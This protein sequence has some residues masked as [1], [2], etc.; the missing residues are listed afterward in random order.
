MSS[1][2]GTLCDCY[3]YQEGIGSSH[4]MACALWENDLFAQGF[5]DWD[6]DLE[7]LVLVHPIHQSLHTMTD[8][9][10]ADVTGDSAYGFSNPLDKVPL[11]EPDASP[12][13][14]ALVDFEDRCLEREEELW[15][16]VQDGV[17]EFPPFNYT[18]DGISR[19]FDVET[20]EWKNAKLGCHC[21]PPEPTQCIRCGVWREKPRGEGTWYEQQWRPSILRS[22]DIMCRCEGN[23]RSDWN[24][25]TCEVK[26]MPCHTGQDAQSQPMMKWTDEMKKKSTKA[27]GGVTAWSGFSPGKVTYAPKCRHKGRELVFPNGKMIYGSSCHAEA[28]KDFVPDFG[29]YL[30]SSWFQQAKQLGIM[31]PW[32]D[33]GLPKI[34]RAHVD[35]AVT[36][37]CSMIERGDTIEVGCIGGHGRTGTF[38]A[39]I[40]MRNGVATPEEAITYIHEHYCEEAIES[41]LQ[42]WY[43]KA[44]YAEDNG[45]PIPEKP[46][47]KSYT[48][49]SSSYQKNKTSVP[50]AKKCDNNCV[51]YCPL[52]NA[53]QDDDAAECYWCGV[54][55][56]N[57]GWLPE[58]Q[59]C[60]AVTKR[61]KEKLAER[62]A[63]GPKKVP[64]A[65]RRKPPKAVTTGTTTTQSALPFEGTEEEWQKALDDVCGAWGGHL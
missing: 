2:L 15:D 61:E 7:S 5:A 49:S 41:E 47:P 58:E 50:T 18:I 33:M 52:C 44:W 48:S 19:V 46:Q 14:L 25:T 12:E 24:C 4:A 16:S 17:L 32:Q 9:E 37:A 3:A 43:I 10:L 40:A 38:L 20:C 6:P 35:A 34:D 55:F 30:D 60:K 57:P 63:A 8:E 65:K 26:R 22:S 13:E 27:K 21:E 42:E 59:W 29:F 31:L 56:T 36:L 51:W 64:D 28:P 1:D 39:L 54:A 45:L 23:K 62:L 11:D 53:D